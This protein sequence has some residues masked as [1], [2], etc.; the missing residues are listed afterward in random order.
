MIIACSEP[1]ESDGDAHER[2]RR[3]DIRPEQATGQQQH[4]R[5]APEGERDRYEEEGEDVRANIQRELCSQRQGGPESFP[6][7]S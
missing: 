7:R 6:L 1:R 4:H 3:G 5:A 2:R